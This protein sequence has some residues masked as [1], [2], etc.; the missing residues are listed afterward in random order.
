M[1]KNY[2]T[3]NKILYHIHVHFKIS[4]L[5]SIYDSYE[6]M[7]QYGLVSSAVNK[8]YKTKGGN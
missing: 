3:K 6:L 2:F 4:C 8:I 7:F 1:R 5:H